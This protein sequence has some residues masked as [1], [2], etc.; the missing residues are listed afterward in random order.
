MENDTFDGEVKQASGTVKEAFGKAD[1]DVKLQA[2]G[3]AEK[4]DGQVERAVHPAP[5]ESNVPRSNFSASE[6][7]GLPLLTDS[8]TPLSSA[9]NIPVLLGEAKTAAE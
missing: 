9:L 5:D 2:A 6:A 4:V 8:P 1:G 3:E 7:L